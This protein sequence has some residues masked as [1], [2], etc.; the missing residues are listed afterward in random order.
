MPPAITARPFLLISVAAISLA[1]CGGSGSVEPNKS[2]APMPPVAEMGSPQAQTASPMPL[3]AGDTLTPILP[4]ASVATTTVSTTAPEAPPASLSAPSATP[5]TSTEERLAKL[6]ATVSSLRSDYDR[7]M[8]AFASLNTTN[9]RIQTLL[10]ELEDGGKVAAAPAK[11][12]TIVTQ[13]TETPV[14]SAPDAA[15]KADPTDADK[16]AEAAPAVSTSAVAPV[17][18]APKSAA[19]SN[20]VTAVRI[21]EHG[22]K[23]RLVFDLTA[24]TKPELRYDLDNAEKLLVVDLPASSWSGKE[25]GKP[26]SPLISGW[27]AQG[28]A[29][30]G[31]SIA[32][33]LKK[34]ARVLS[35][36]FLKAEGKDPARLVIDIAAAN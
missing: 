19:G 36:E 14:I 5:P 11:T 18:A 13:T 23:T 32:I 25:S 17:T 6:E 30:G 22:A 27:T 24:R 7:I 33:Q 34:P 4:A 28:G 1:G 16:T 21:G 10:D 20:S 26:N 15:A 8:P 35:T 2:A 3:S 12:T 31:T 9:E 29:Q